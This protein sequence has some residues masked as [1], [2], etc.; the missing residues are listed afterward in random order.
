MA[1]ARNANFELL[2]IISMIFILYHHFARQTK[3]DFGDTRTKDKQGKLLPPDKRYFTTFRHL[4]IIYLGCLGKV[5][6][7][8]FILLSG[9][10][11]NTRSASLKSIIRLYY[12]TVTWTWSI[13]AIMYFF[14][15][16]IWWNDFKS[17]A[18]PV[19]SG[20]Y[21]YVSTYFLIMIFT[22]ALGLLVKHLSQRQLAG[23]VTTLLLAISVTRYFPMTHRIHEFFYCRFM[24]LFVLY[25]VGAYFSQ[26]PKTLKNVPAYC[27]GGA[28]WMLN[29][30]DFYTLYY[31]NNY[32]S[33]FLAK[34]GRDNCDDKLLMASD[35]SPLALLMAI[36]LF[37]WARKLDLDNT[38]IAKYICFF[39]SLTFG[40]YVAHE[41]LLLRPYLWKI[42][43]FGQ[44]YKSPYF[45]PLLV[46][47]PMSVYLACSFGEYLRHCIFGKLEPYIVNNLDYYLRTTGDKLGDFFG[48]DEDSKE[49]ELA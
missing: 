37:L 7:H 44:H 8:V 6:V 29:L 14:I 23:T 21:W 31:F 15:R 45:F 12:R 46:V 22:P 33:E 2:R 24:L 3:W 43:N 35:Y 27:W 20:Q 16:G 38:R 41:N 32:K 40:V 47:K 26:Y 18:W 36:S 30:I 49:S 11:Y 4:F 13:L 42:L 1:A 17:Q 34:N 19:L 5:G 10:F 9:Y 25:L 39:S 48:L 28:L